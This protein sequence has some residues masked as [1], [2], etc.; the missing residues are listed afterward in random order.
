[1]HRIK[2]ISVLVFLPA[3]VVLAAAWMWPANDDKADVTDPEIGAPAPNFTL[4]GSDGE[5]YTLAD[6]EGSYVVLEWLNF[7]CPY[8]KRH[9]NSGNMPALQKKYTEKGVTWLSIVSSAPGKQGYYEP[10][11][12]NE[13]NEEMGGRMDAILLDP[14]GEVGRTYAAITTPHMFV[15]GPD[16]TLLYKGGIDD[17]PRAPKE[18][19]PSISSY[20][21]MALDAALSGE[22]IETTSARP[23]G[24]DVK[25]D[26]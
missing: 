16:G 13:K 9:Y 2:R 24:C 7:G 14:E 21:S 4:P 20:V 8:V 17:R 1:M 11:G 5:T 12:M 3:L 25:Y 6:F 19:T 10:D 15:I 18:E 22:E 26:S 23:Y